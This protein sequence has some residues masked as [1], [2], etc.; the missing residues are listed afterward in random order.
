MPVKVGQQVRVGDVLA[1]LD[2][3]DFEVEVTNAKAGL[4]SAKAQLN[5]AKLEYDRAL[6]IQKSD[7]GAVSQSTI[8]LR[9][10]TFEQADAAH[11]SSQALLNASQDKLSYATLKAPFDGVVVQRFVDNFQD[12]SS[13]SAIFRLVDM[14][15]IEMDVNIPENLIS[16]L[17]YVQNIRVTFDAFPNVAIPAKIKEVSNEASQSTRTFQVR[18]IMDPP[19]GI[20]I[21]PGMSGNATG[22]VVRA[23]DG[24]QAIIVPL[25]SIFSAADATTTYVW[26]FDKDSQTVTKRQVQKGQLI[27]QGVTITQGLQPGDWIATA[28]VH[29]LI[30]G[31]KVRLLADEGKQ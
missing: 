21:L 28:G 24:N 30:E 1:I 8:D 27:D 14:S 10:A 6:R 26:L 9:H 2:Q 16:N 31:Q 17:P 4:A 19:D 5:N 23:T 25:K 13:N 29:F 20:D 3:R 18:L 11:G 15:K 22:K 12:I 7:S